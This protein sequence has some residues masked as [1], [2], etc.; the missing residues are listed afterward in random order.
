M[1]HRAAAASAAARQTIVLMVC[2]TTLAC[3]TIAGCLVAFVAVPEGANTGSL[4]AI[5]MGSIPA[6]VASLL[7]VMQIR[8]VAATV[9]EVADDTQRLA[10][11]LGDAKFRSAVADVVDP[12]YH[13]EAYDGHA[14]KAR[15]AVQHAQA[16]ERGQEL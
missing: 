7:A 12:A 16:Q 14:D 10:N 8:N 4:I 11:G 5:L 3:F 9:T 13:S 2:I 15:V 1:P 6:T